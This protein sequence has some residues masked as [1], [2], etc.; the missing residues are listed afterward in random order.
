VSVREIEAVVR[1]RLAQQYDAPVVR[2][3]AGRVLVLGGKALAIAREAAEAAGFD[4]AGT[5]IGQLELDSL[6]W[7]DVPAG[8]LDLW[9]QHGA[10]AAQDGELVTQ[11]LEGDPPVQILAQL[12]GWQLVRSIDGATGWI[13][14]RDHALEPHED[15]PG[16][17]PA[18]AFDAEAFITAVEG[19][20]GVPYRWGG[21]TRD[22]VDCSGL[23]QRTAYESN[24]HW[25]PR[26][27]THLMKVG[28][29]VAPSKVQRGDILV[30]RR[31]PA[32]IDPDAPPAPANQG[33]RH[34][35]H[36][37]VA[38]GPNAT[39]HAS[40]DAWQVVTEPLDSLR[41]RYRV[42]AVRRAGGS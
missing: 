29:R 39:I 4:D 21:T 23:V 17:N 31:D 25:L 2:V 38:A 33:G 6:P 27:S 40:R 26:H 13:E 8:G 42:L 18:E 3:D 20:I 19:F 10:G 37:A 7:H 34:P 28:E 12:E 32:T 30:L 1:E 11:L 36:V 9:R 41:Q 24:G 15:A 22:G 5:A 16:R 35:M 14:P